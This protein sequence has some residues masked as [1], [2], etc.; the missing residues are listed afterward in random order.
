VVHAGAT[1]EAGGA[2]MAGL[3][4]RGG[5]NMGAW[6]AQCLSTVVAAGA[7]RGDAGM[8]HSGATFEAGSA[9]MAGFTRCTGGDM[10]TWF[11]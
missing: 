10:G 9:L 3:T 5:W 11:A 8:V 2:L 7:A 1:F 4:S 6:F